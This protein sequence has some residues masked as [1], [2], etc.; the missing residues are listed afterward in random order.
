MFKNGKL[1]LKN[2]CENTCGWKS[3]LK[4]VK[5]YLKTKNDCL[6]TQIKYPLYNLLFL[7]RV[8]TK[9]PDR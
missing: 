7:E 2:I 6:K 1:L 8:S 4:Y 5:C 3:A 9:F